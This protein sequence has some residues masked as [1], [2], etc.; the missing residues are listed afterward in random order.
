MLALARDI[1]GC[2]GM[3]TGIVI[4]ALIIVRNQGRQL[5]AQRQQAR[6]QRRKPE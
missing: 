1:A 4:A 3:P 2:R 5:R 6:A